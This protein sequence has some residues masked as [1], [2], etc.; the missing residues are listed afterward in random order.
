MK[1]KKTIV[2]LFYRECLC[3]TPFLAMID[4][5]CKHYSVKVISC[6]KPGDIDK[7]EKMYE[8]KDVEFLSKVR[9]TQLPKVLRSIRA[10]I[11][12]NPYVSQDFKKE[13][14]KIIE[15]ISY[16]LLWVVHEY[17]LNEFKDF[18]KDK[19]YVVSLY[20]LNDS[21]LKFLK[22]IKESLHKAQEVIVAEYNR[23]CIT[24]TWLQLEKTPTVIPNKPLN[25][26]RERFIEND[27]SGVLKDKKII[28]YQ[29][30]IVKNRNLDKI[31]EA[32]SDMPEYTLVL[33]GKDG[34]DY[35]KDLKQINP[36][37]IYISH[38]DPPKHLYIT[39]YAHIAILK[40]DFVVLNSIYCAPNKTW[41]Y[42]GFGIPTLCNAIP[43]LQYTIGSYHAGVCTDL[44][45]VKSIKEAVIE[46]ETNYNYYSENALHYFES[47]DLEKELLA[48]ANR[49]IVK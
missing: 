24:R 4:G 44:D 45:D 26:P 40:Y 3:L 12:R 7:L 6:E 37:I 48:I 9:Q 39:S 14:R 35:V 49:N 36:N 42:S 5:L 15:T 41:E 1:E 46:I 33:M 25:H 34:S 8:N 10:R 16:D 38:I 18:L 43:G 23:A 30:S 11:N 27:F 28:I 31:C 13:A 17:T 19:Q 20:E 29:G 47:V 32:L 21:N 2:F 22:G